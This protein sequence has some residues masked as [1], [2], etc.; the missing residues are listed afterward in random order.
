MAPIVKGSCQPSKARMTEGLKAT[1]KN[2]ARYGKATLSSF[3]HSA[4]C[5]L[6]QS[7]LPLRR[8]GRER[9]ARPT[10]YQRLKSISRIKKNNPSVTL[11]EGFPCFLSVLQSK[12][13]DVFLNKCARSVFGFRPAKS[14]IARIIFTVYVLDSGGGVLPCVQ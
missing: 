1:S 11:A 9:A 12:I 5:I 13:D 8:E 3:R 14:R 10:L 4:F 2:Q 6:P 7:H